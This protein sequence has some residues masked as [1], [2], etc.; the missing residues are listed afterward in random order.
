M[1]CHRS[2]TRR[3]GLQFRKIANPSFGNDAFVAWLLK[4]PRTI[5]VE[6][7]RNNFRNLFFN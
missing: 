7:K 3:F 4:I 2:P 6:F 5:V 1:N